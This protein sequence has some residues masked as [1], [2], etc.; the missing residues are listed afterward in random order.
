MLPHDRSSFFSTDRYYNAVLHFFQRELEND[1]DDI[2]SHYVF[3]NDCFVNATVLAKQDGVFCGQEESA[4]LF[5]CF[6]PKVQLRWNICDGEK[7]SKGKNILQLTGSVFD[8]VKAERVLVNTLSRMSGIATQTNLITKA[9]KTAIAATRKTQWSYLDKKAV[10]KG[11]GLTH[12]MGLFDAVL[13]KENHA[14]AFGNGTKNIL[15][16][17]YHALNT[18]NTAAFVECEV[19][20][21]AEFLEIYQLFLQTEYQKIPKIIM[22]D[23]FEPE[24]ITSCMNKMDSLRNR[25]EKNIFLEISGGI[26]QQNIFEYDGLGCDVIS[27]G[28]LTHSV[29]PIDFSLRITPQDTE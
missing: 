10:W 1:G 5:A 3:E 25:H 8:I 15:Q 27:M 13:I 26:T 19:E 24:E 29:L 4:W 17:A 6:F 14:I 12:R 20:N 28:S 16:T 18:A 2:T 21:S 7:F 22:F 9:C 11:G 23:N